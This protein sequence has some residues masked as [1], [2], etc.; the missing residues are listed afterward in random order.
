MPKVQYHDYLGLEKVL[1]AQKPLSF[2]FCQSEVLKL[3]IGD[4]T[5]LGKYYNYTFVDRKSGNDLQGTLNKHNI[6]RFRREI[7]RAQ[8]MDSYL[9]IVIESNVE[10]MIKNSIQ[11]H[12]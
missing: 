9:F 6:E 5:T 4:Y 7:Q 1:N 11:L 2:D 3:D 8:E 10:K 12:D